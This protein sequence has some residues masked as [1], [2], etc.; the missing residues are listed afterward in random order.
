MAASADVLVKNFEVLKSRVNRFGIY[1][2]IISLVTIFVSTIMVAF[3][4]T[5]NISFTTLLYAQDHN[6]ALRVLN[7]LPFI[8]AFWGQYTGNDIAYRAS[9][10]IAEETDD[11][12]AQTTE[13]K[14]KSLHDSTHDALTE[15]PNRALFYDLL[16]QAILVAS[17]E[18]RKAAV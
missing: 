10:I 4:M 7:F 16:R 15:L 3:Q 17:R 11:L 1:G 18:I 9:A 13:W 14:K 8:F 2:L 5:G 12:R 6:F